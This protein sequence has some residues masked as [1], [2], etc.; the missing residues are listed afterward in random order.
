MQ[1]VKP[2]SDTE[3]RAALVAAHRRRSLFPGGSL[4]TSIAVVRR[5][6][7]R[8][9]QALQRATP[10]DAP[11]LLDYRSSLLR[12]IA[13]KR[14]HLA[15]LEGALEEVELAD[16]GRLRGFVAGLALAVG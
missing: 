16:V 15:E 8:S 9:L 1:Y 14:R 4:E 7:D 13:R 12:D 11:E 3:I 10:F 6:L 5:E 2:L